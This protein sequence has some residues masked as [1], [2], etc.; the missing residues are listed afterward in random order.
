MI[1]NW[2]LCGFGM[3][4]VTDRASGRTLGVCGAHF[5]IHWPEREIGWHIWDARAEGKGIAYE[6][7]CAVRGHLFRDLGWDTAVSYIARGNT[8]SIRLA[9]RL[10]AQPDPLAAFPGG[11][12]GI[13][14]RHPNPE[15]RT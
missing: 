1:G 15:V 2:T 13:V 5:P 3:F 9:E 11:L 14:Y 7:A 6:A 12:E 4:A 8:R 10:G